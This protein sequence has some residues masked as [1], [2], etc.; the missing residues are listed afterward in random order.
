MQDAYYCGCIEEPEV[1]GTLYDFDLDDRN[2]VARVMQGEFFTFMEASN[3]TDGRTFKYELP[4]NLNVECVQEKNRSDTGYYRQV[5]FEATEGNCTYNV[6]R[7][8][9]GLPTT[10]QDIGF[11]IYPNTEPPRTGVFFDMD[12]SS[13][14]SVEI[15]KG[16]LLTVRM[17]EAATTH[18]YAWDVPEPELKCVDMLNDNYGNFVTGY[19]Q[20]VF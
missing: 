17:N 12:V 9:V 15:N 20:W 10:T 2:R 11:R 13:D 3:S 16:G 7:E 8:A 6:T 1:I 14:R 19:H 5:V 4:D 18:G